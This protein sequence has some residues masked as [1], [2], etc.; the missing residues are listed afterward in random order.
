VHRRWELL[1]LPVKASNTRSLR[2][3]RATA[4]AKTASPV[5]R[6]LAEEAMVLGNYSSAKAIALVQ[7]ATAEARTASEAALGGLNVL[8][9][10][11][12]QPGVNRDSA[13]AVFSKLRLQC[14]LKTLEE[15]S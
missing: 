8:R 12:D 3:F 1:P 4:W 6:Q 2:T 5:E 11:V 13:L 15:A 10:L 7:R 14:V 9:S